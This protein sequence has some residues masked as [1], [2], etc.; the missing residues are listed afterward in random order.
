MDPDA[1]RDEVD[2]WVR[3]GV[4]TEAQAEAILG[5]YE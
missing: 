2:T 4:I 1:L 3:D 5:R